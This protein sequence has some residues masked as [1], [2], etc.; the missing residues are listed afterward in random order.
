[1]PVSTCMNPGAS[2]CLNRRAGFELN[3][4]RGQGFPP[5]G[6]GGGSERQRTVV[7]LRRSLCQEALGWPPPFSVMQGKWP[8]RGR[9]AVS[10]QTSGLRC[11]SLGHSHPLSEPALPG[12]NRKVKIPRDNECGE[13]LAQGLAPVTRV[14]NYKQLR[15]MVI[16]Q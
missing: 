7:T 16:N 3:S 4:K 2:P 8:C 1:M 12:C 14:S 13:G 6:P 15:F 9:P 11:V 10:T 5:L